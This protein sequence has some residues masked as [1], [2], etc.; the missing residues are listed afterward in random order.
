[1]NQHHT[2][3]LVQPYFDAV[4]RG[5][6]LFEVRRNDRFFQCGDTVTLRCWHARSCTFETK[7]P[8]LTFKIGPVLQGGRFGIEPGYCVFSLLPVDYQP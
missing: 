4:K 7:E 8:N 5:D 2:L 1:M 3:K 6:K